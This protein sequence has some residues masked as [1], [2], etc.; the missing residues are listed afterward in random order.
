MV[1]LHG[2]SFAYPGQGQLLDGVSLRFPENK[3][4]A[5]LGPNG[6]GKS[7]LLKVAC[8]LLKPS[9]GCVTLSGQDIAKLRP[10]E[11]AK[12]VAL[13]SQ[14]NQPPEIPVRDLVAYGRYPHQRYGHG[15][16]RQDEEIVERA[17][18]QVKIT[19]SRD[20][21]VSRLSGGQQQ[22]AYIAMALAQDTPVVF[23]DEPTT[24]LDVHICFEIMELVRSLHEAG[25]TVI[26]VLHDLSLALEYADHV[27]L[28]DQ[29]RIA[30]Q[31]S[32][33]EIISAGVLDEVFHI[34]TR[35]FS[36]DGKPIYHFERRDAAL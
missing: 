27:I 6:S 35:Q 25:K 29:G 33:Q 17:M 36:A 26:M 21:L 15:L 32:P 23:L 16:T 9:H 2:I 1:E 10:R 30:A 5:I 3:I 28:M 18:A 24:C 19:E 31:G 22:R 20:H 34:R 14:S 12:Q 13:L 4:T 8:R 11:L 7:T